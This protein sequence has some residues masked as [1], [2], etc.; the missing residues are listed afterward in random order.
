MLEIEVELAIDNNESQI[1]EL[2]IR[3]EELEDKIKKLEAHNAEVLRVLESYHVAIH[4]LA[5][6][7]GNIV[8]GKL[9]IRIKK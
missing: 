8:S 6:N 2:D 3:V 1:N 4:A 9:V 5:G 7:H